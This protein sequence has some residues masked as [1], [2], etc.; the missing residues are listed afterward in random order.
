LGL[1]VHKSYWPD[2]R[3]HLPEVGQDSGECGVCQS[4]VSR[5][6][7]AASVPSKSYR[8]VILNMRMQ[9]HLIRALGCATVALLP[10]AHR[11]RF[12][13]SNPDLPRVA[14]AGSSS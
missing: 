1:S 12:L 13:L 4:A 6:R 3:F 14:L 9:Y 7:I 8:L 10:V 2:R 5:M 11:G